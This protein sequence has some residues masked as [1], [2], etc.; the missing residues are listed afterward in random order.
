MTESKLTP[1]EL[2][3]LVLLSRNIIWRYQLDLF[4]DE[5][6]RLILAAVQRAEREVLAEIHRRG[7]GATEWTEARS[8][9]LL[10]EMSDLTLGIRTQLV[11]DISDV[12]SQAGASSYLTH[13]AIVS[14][15]GRVAPFNAVALSAA[16]LRSQ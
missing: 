9:A 15:D 12:A 10:D 5:T 11:R 3:A 13:N 2:Q 4:E 16:Q 1:Q 8:L 6:L 14:F 7:A